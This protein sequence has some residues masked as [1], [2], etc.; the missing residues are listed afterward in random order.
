V[1]D[2]FRSQ[3]VA[4]TGTG[5]A[6]PGVSLSPVG[7]L[8]F[9]A[10][11]LG[12]S[13]AAQTITLTNNGGVTLTVT[14]IAASGD[15][16]LLAGANT[17]GSSVAPGAVCTVQV[18]FT[19]A[20]TGTRTGT[21]TFSDNAASSP[22]IMQLAGTGVDFTLATNGSASMS[23]ASGQTATYGLILSSA[24][25]LTGSVAF[26][27]AGVPAH[28]ICTV[29][30]ASGSLGG[31]TSVTVTVVTG[32]S[33]VRLDRPPMPWDT[34]VV[35]AGLLLPIFTFVRRGRRSL[36]LLAAA[37]VIVGLSGCSMGRNVPS[38][39][40]VTTTVVTPSGTYPIMVAGS[41]TGLV[42]SVNLTLVVQ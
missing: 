35:W 4:L 1:T 40:T 19:P 2:E 9:G 10:V 28:S 5:L 12:L 20:A 14:S 11:G 13:G 27:C 33:L 7:G 23:V 39:G 21:V 34:Y 24:T 25:G 31:T 32:S 22:Q 16:A 37:L 30:P 36:G 15:F 18:V 38:T 26:T 17:C 29:N 3:T 41:S 42:R 8:S 6:P